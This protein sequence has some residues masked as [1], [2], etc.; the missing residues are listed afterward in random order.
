M[1]YG[2]GSIS[3]AGSIRNHNGGQQ[4][5]TP[6]PA[7]TEPGDEP[8]PVEDPTEEPEVDEPDPEPTSA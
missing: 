6:D 7:P 3:R 2:R 4:M 5:T 8:V 1:T